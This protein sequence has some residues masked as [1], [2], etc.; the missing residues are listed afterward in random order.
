MALGAWLGPVDRCPLGD[1]CEVCGSGHE[2]DVA[3][4]DTPVGVFCATVCA[5]YTTP[6]KAPPVRGWAQ[7]VERVAAHCGHLGIDVDQ[8]AAIRHAERDP[9]G[10]SVIDL[11]AINAY[12]QD[13]S[14]P[15]TGGGGG[16]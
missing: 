3:T 11:A 4:Y 15:T 1:C 8:M 12:D 10:D 13:T 6:A 2:L 5:P 16:W 14:G 7:A 9:G